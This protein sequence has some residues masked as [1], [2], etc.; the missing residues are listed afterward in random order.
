MDF[1]NTDQRWE[2]RFQSQPVDFLSKVTY[3]PRLTHFQIPAV[4]L[5]S[6]VAAL[7]WKEVDFL[8]LNL[9]AA[10]CQVLKSFPFNSV[11]F[12]VLIVNV[13]Y[14]DALDI[15]ELDGLLTSQGYLMAKH[16]NNDGDAIYVHE[17]Y[18]QMLEN[19]KIK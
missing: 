3:F 8:R 17:K 11:T 16:I 1:L 5:Y 10:V 6:I 7:G 18:K 14:C 9:D 2:D 13:V 12:K 19:V 15:I 4:P